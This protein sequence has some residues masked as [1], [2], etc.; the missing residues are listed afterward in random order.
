M[1]KVIPA[2]VGDEDKEKVFVPVPAVAVIVS[3]PTTPTFKFK[4]AV[5]AVS[6][7][8]LATVIVFEVFSDRDVVISR[9]LVELRGVAVALL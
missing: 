9:F 2:F 8:G 6:D 4:V 1:F 5:V 3:K 7:I